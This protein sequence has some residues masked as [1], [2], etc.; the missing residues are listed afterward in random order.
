MAFGDFKGVGKIYWM[1]CLFTNVKRLSDIKGPETLISRVAKITY[2]LR[3]R[4]LVYVQRKLLKALMSLFSNRCE[5]WTL[6]L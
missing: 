6:S 2:V 1:I 4:D 5:F 3:D